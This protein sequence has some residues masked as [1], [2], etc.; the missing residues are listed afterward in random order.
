M[1]ASDVGA[2]K[3]TLIPRVSWLQVECCGSPSR[4]QG[5]R[6]TWLVA[7]PTWQRVWRLISSHSLAL[8]HRFEYS[9]DLHVGR[10]GLRG[11]R[12]PPE[13][14]R[15]SSVD[16]QEWLDWAK[17][18]PEACPM[19]SV[20]K[21]S[22]SLPALQASRPLILRLVHT[23]FRYFAYPH[24]RSVFQ[25]W[26]SLEITLRCHLWGHVCARKL[27]V[28]SEDEIP[29]AP[30][31]NGVNAL[32]SFLRVLNRLCGHLVDSPVARCYGCRPAV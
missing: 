16:R 28:I 23:V 9:L 26:T 32:S 10:L 29:L 5:W 13:T 2:G 27:T 1:Q 7:S 17:R 18:G 25:P 6:P 21:G 8:P 22:R 31:G 24:D 11:S 4:D 30:S 3:I 15:L 20:C 14:F 19:H 12:R